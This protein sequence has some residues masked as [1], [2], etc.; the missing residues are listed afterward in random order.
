MLLLRVFPPVI[1]ILLWATN[2]EFV[3]MPFLLFVVGMQN[4]MFVVV[5][6]SCA[7][8]ELLYWYW[9][10]GWVTRVAKDLSMIQEA[11]DDF[12]V[13]GLP[14]AIQGA[15]LKVR[16]IVSL[17]W[18]WVVRKTTKLF[19]P[20]GRLVWWFTHTFFIDRVH[21]LTETLANALKLGLGLFPAVGMPM[22]IVLCRVAPTRLGI[23]S[24]VL[25]NAIKMTIYGLIELGIIKWWSNT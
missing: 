2:V 6:V 8:G 4:E 5:S 15:A 22:G 17:T 14:E 10:S 19:Q 1:A 25:G 12:R 9:F 18:A 3:V 24:L 23:V 11:I 16:S 13:E 20:K 21:W 7:T